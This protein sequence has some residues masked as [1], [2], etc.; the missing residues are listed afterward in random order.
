MTDEEALGF[1]RV[2]DGANETRTA[3]VELMKTIARYGRP[4]SLPDDV[5]AA[6]NECEHIVGDDTVSELL[7]VASHA[8]REREHQRPTRRRRFTRPVEP[9]SV[10]MPG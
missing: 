2:L 8:I 9:T 7:A 1:A 10:C 6:W 3:L 4:S 5:R